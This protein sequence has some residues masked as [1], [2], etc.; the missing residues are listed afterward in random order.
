MTQMGA[1]LENGVSGISGPE[2]QWEVAHGS[3]RARAAS[4]SQD[5]Q[6][7]S[8]EP[9]QAPEAELVGC[10]GKEPMVR[11]TELVP[12]TLCCSVSF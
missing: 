10:E 3:H 12:T 6:L 7:R 1:A 4:R 5:W 8:G 2:W 9:G 11:G